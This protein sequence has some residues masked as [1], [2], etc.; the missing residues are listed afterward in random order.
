MVIKMRQLPKGGD[1]GSKENQPQMAWV[2]S[3][4]A[5]K[6]ASKTGKEAWDSGGNPEW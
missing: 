5:E 1:W 6:E 3:H 4:M 2:G